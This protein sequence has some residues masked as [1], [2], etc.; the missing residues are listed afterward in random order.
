MFSSTMEYYD[1]AQFIFTNGFSDDHHY[2]AEW[3]SVSEV[4]GSEYVTHVVS[5][6]DIDDQGRITENR[7]YWNPQTVPNIGDFSVEAA[8]YERRK[9]DRRRAGK[10]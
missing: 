5:I 1:K 9:G 2:V 10:S 6:G 7:D 8:A 3:T 4:Q